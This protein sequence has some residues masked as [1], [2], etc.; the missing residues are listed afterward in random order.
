MLEK[1]L[2]Q[3]KKDLLDCYKK[4]EEKYKREQEMNGAGCNLRKGENFPMKIDLLD[5]ACVAGDGGEWV[6]DTSLKETP[7]QQSTEN[8]NG[9]IVFF[10][11]E[12]QWKYD[13]VNRHL[14]QGLSNS[15]QNS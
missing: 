5:K 4:N 8:E 7:G 13:G 6:G 3:T 15:P 2:T 1:V 9:I 10:H 14:N 11:L 12:Q